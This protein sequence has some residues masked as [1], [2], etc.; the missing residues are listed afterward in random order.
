[1]NC[2]EFRDRLE[3]SIEHRRPPD[4]AAAETHLRGCDEA[5]CRRQWLAALLL[6][7][8]IAEW[9]D[10]QPAVD[11]ADGVVSLWRAGSMIP[12]SPPADGVRLVNGRTPA[13][14]GRRD[15]TRRAISPG[16]WSA[17]AVAAVL[18]VGTL[19]LISS[20]P[21]GPA[22]MSRQTHVLPPV[23]DQDLATRPNPTL[24]A[25]SDPALQD[26][27][28]SYV[29]LMQNATSAVTDVVVLTLG[30]DEQLEEPSPAARW[31]HRWR[32]ELDPVRDDVDDAVERFLKTFPDSFPST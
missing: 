18:C 20:A 5:E 16:A 12:R 14:V 7:R 23:A 10:M 22:P 28:R 21:I 15:G 8:S 26:V 17:I 6:D 19:A 4:A 13:M 2:T 24:V 29:G 30:G 25:Q 9:R 3:S 31:V 11:V 1:M 32:D 27:G